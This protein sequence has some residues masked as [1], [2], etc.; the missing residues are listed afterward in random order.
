VDPIPLSI[1]CYSTVRGTAFLLGTE[2]PSMERISTIFVFMFPFY[3]SSRAGTNFNEVQEIKTNKIEIKGASCPKL[4][5]LQYCIEKASDYI[6]DV[7]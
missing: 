4:K 2:S 7:L 6:H 1:R 3:L 5:A